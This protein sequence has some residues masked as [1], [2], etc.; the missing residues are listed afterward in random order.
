M[1]VKLFAWL[2]G[3]AL[4]LGVVFFVKYSFEHNLITPQMRIAIGALTGFGL[5][6]GGL[7]VPRPRFTVTAHTLC[8]TGVVIL[9]GVTYAASAFYHFVHL[10]PAFAIMAAITAAAFLLAVRLKA[11]VVA[12]LGLLGGFLTPLLLSTGQNH[13]IFLFSY[14]AFLDVG[15]IAVA[16]RRRWL[17]LV[18]LAAIATAVM[19][20]GWLQRNFASPEVGIA[21]TIFLGFEALFLISFWLD[22]G[23]AW[24]RAASAVSAAVALI[25]AASLLLWQDLGQKP[26]IC[27]S[28]A[29]AA[30][31]GLVAWPLRRRTLQSGPLLGGAAAFLI[32]SLWNFGYLN[33][34]LLKWGLGYFLVF[35]AF[36]TALPVVL[37]RLR[38]SPAPNYPRWI[39][40][41][42]ALGLILMLW[43]ALHI[44]ASVELWLAV[45]IVDLA[46]IY[47]AARTGSPLGVLG[48]LV[49]TLAALA[50][51]LMQTPAAT[52]D[53]GGLLAVVAGFA[54][55][56]CG[57]SVILQKQLRSL[58]TGV[59]ADSPERQTL[60]HLPSISAVM[61]FALLISAVLRLH[62]QDPSTIFSV[63][64]L[65]VAMILGLAR[66]SQSAVLP[67]IALIC[68]ALLEYCWRAEIDE[69]AW[70]PLRWYL[71]FTGLIFSF[72]FLAES[73]K[74]TRS[75]PWVTAALAPVLHYPLIAETIRQSWPVFWNSAGGLV[76]AA[77]ALPP[78][79]ACFHLRHRL[80][81][82]HPARMT[83]LAWFGGITLL[84][85]TL[86][87]PT[88]F[89]H[90]WLTLS[91]ALEGVALLW[92]FHRLP[93]PGLRKVGF[94]LLC[95]AFVR[96]ALNPAVLAYHS[97]SGI[98]IWNWYLYTY[99][100]AAACFFV[101][102]RLTAPPRDRLGDL[103][104]PATLHSLGT[105]LL[106]LLLNI[107]IADY[108]STSPTL[109]FEFN[110]DLARDMTYSI[111]W[112]FFALTLLLIGMHRQVAGIRYAG[113]GLLVITLAKLFLHDLASLDQLYRIGAFVVVSVV[114]IG[115]SYLYQRFLSLKD[116][117]LPA[118]VKK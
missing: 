7:L 9:Y 64:V 4:F 29:L 101:A 53:L 31:A 40:I 45:F 109:R 63:G 72:P 2:G 117:E 118:T 71:L 90:E 30:D 66:W 83:V 58:L 75:A 19:Q 22:A 81:V 106:F 25:F 57:A 35:A 27:L 15:L 41:F 98:P 14:L 89:H 108:F 10:T 36:H 92:L 94:V 68:T 16:F 116:A 102:G 24:T 33:A 26:W 37:Q 96:L 51:W 38:P 70:L 87:F 5:I 107:E 47:L 110:V 11:Q 28:I 103:S 93:L 59:S 65:L 82:E 1:G 79:A 91:W 60:E 99:G 6:A 85:V 44:G 52:P 49:L 88:Q 48:A 111:A 114:L 115:A 56:F 104:L 76:P 3:L 86:I 105:I 100:I 21:A 8:A 42:P 74:T 39:Q 12:I 73:R 17:Y 20:L 78:L 55:L 113:I 54:T 46:A 97:R 77:F 34:A 112:S 23:E 69:T 95:V 13:P 61:P 43:P 62:P 67:P 18:T 84:F 32:L 80:P 50:M